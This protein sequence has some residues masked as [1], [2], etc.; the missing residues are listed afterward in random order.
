MQ[1]LRPSLPS[2]PP[3]CIANDSI[4]YEN[5]LNLCSIEWQF[6]ALAHSLDVAPMLIHFMFVDYEACF[7][8]CKYAMFTIS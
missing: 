2:L 3:S 1:T 8:E 4:V 7:P 5:F 6:I